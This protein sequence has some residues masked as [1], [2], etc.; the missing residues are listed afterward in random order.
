MLA[1]YTR[2]WPDC[3]IF[4]CGIRSQFRN[5]EDINTTDDKVRNFHII[6]ENAALFKFYAPHVSSLA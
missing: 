4:L 3:A 1:N 2:N 6:F 5:D